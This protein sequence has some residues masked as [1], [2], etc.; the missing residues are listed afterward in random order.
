[1]SDCTPLGLTLCGTACRLL[2]D[3]ADNCGTCGNVCA[4][5]AHAVG[6]CSGGTCGITC[7]NGYGDCDGNQANGC[8]AALSPYFPDQDGDGFGAMS[9]M[10]AGSACTAPPGNATNASDCLDT[11]S[12]G[13]QVHP[14]QKSYFTASYTSPSG[15]PSFDYDCDGKETTSPAFMLGGSCAPCTFGY[16]PVGGAK[17]ANAYCGSVTE[18]ACTVGSSI[19]C[20]ITG[21]HSAVGCN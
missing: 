1:V 8:E 18:D 3:S 19:M 9:S 21:G 10:A 12:L 6:E 16:I 14:G 11:G 2:T 5:A 7:D 20:S 15:T 13:A 17:Y 4:G